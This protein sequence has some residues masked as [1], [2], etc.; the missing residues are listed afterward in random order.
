VEG[1]R[2]NIPLLSAVMDPMRF[3]E[4]RLTTAYLA[5]EFPEGFAD[6]EPTPW[7]SDLMTA[8]AAYIH[9]V[10]AARRANG[11]KPRTD[12]IVDL[13]HSR[14]SV[15]LTPDDAGLTIELSDEA[16]TLRL[17]EVD[18]RPGLPLLRG[19][20]DGRPF[21]AHA[22]PLAEGYRIRHRAAG[23]RALVL[24]P[25]LL[26]LHDRLPERAPADVSRLVLSP[27]PG[28]VVSVAVV[29]GQEIK[30][31]EAVA[32]IEAMKMQNLVRAERDGVIALVAVVPGDSVAA[33][34]VL[35]ELV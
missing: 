20:L 19:R 35:A 7:Q 4:G 30:A 11:R 18:W 34:Q 28:L 26:A 16:R 15:R 12:W 27:M 21:A 14:R 33:D 23:A 5:E 9:V 24:S 3:R 1:V 8:A 32:V 10:Q 31:G 29:A 2:H 25:L 22:A 6:A 13:G 17:T